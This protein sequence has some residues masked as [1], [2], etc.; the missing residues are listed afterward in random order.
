MMTV[1]NLLSKKSIFIVATACLI[2][3]TAQAEKYD[4]SNIDRIIFDKSL[5][6]LGNVGLEFLQKFNIYGDKII[7]SKQWK[8]L[9][10]FKDETLLRTFDVALGGSPYGPKM[11][12]GDLKTPEGKYTI[13][14]KKRESEYHKALHVSYPNSKDIE[15]AQ[16]YSK[17]HGVNL[18]PGGAIMI[19]GFPN[20][21]EAQFSELHPLVNWTNGCIAVTNEQIDDLFELVPEKTEIEICPSVQQVHK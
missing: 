3:N 12:A 8:K 4:C 6:N 5:K 18:N 15:N 16:K 21:R 10:L 1:K 13:D 17:A 19:H 14:F 20:G 9:Y 7:V 11:F 2:V